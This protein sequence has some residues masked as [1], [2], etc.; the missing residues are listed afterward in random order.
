M[1]HNLQLINISYRNEMR[2]RDVENVKMTTISRDSCL[3]RVVLFM[4]A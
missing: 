1:L 3:A 4:S 2:L